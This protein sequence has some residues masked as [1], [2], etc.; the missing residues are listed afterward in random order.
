MK[1]CFY[2]ICTKIASLLHSDRKRREPLWQ[3]RIRSHVMRADTVL[4]KTSDD[5]GTARSTNASGSE[6]ICV[7]NSLACQLIDVG[8]DR[9]W[10]TV[11]TKMWADVFRRNPKDVGR[12][13]AGRRHHQHQAGEQNRRNFLDSGKHDVAKTDEVN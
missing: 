9:V 5:G 2:V 12:R 8:R 3:F 6:S 10:I 13:G 4:V 7:A 1:I 11:A